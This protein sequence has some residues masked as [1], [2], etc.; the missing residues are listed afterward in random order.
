VIELAVEWTSGF[1]TRGCQSLGDALWCWLQQVCVAA[2]LV[3]SEST[4]DVGHFV[5]GAHCARLPETC[6]A[7]WQILQDIR[8]R[9][10]AGAVTAVRVSADEILRTLI[11]MS[12][13]RRVFAMAAAV[14]VTSWLGLVGCAAHDADDRDDACVWDGGLEMESDT[15]VLLD[16]NDLPVRDATGRVVG[17]AVGDATSGRRWFGSVHGVPMLISRLPAAAARGLPALTR[18]VEHQLLMTMSVAVTCASGCACSSYVYVYS[19]EGCSTVV[20]SSLRLILTFALQFAL[21]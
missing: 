13:R 6:G 17:V 1:D 5:A 21:S 10:V 11:G 8:Q 20:H 15:Q 9:S 12:P 3:H 7:P 16:A 14:T 18:C 4:R 19:P 2:S